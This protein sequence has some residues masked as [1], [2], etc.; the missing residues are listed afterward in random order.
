M[1]RSIADFFDDI[2]NYSC[3]AE[4]IIGTA[5]KEALEGDFL[6]SAGVLRCLEII[7]EA[8][9]KIP[10]ET[11]EKYKEIPWKSW[12]GLR[13]RLIHKYWDVGTWELCTIP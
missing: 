7:G 6:K 11:R 1:T 12:A 5:S 4:E 9:K 2:V 3:K 8:V 13:D 10:G